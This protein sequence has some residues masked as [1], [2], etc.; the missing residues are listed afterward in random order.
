MSGLKIG[1]VLLMGA[2]GLLELLDVLG[3]PFPEGGL[4][5]TVP[6]LPLLRRRVYLWTKLAWDEANGEGCMR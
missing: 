5:L 3:S 2:D 4:S 6:L 1:E